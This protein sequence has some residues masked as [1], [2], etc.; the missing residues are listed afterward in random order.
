MTT[1]TLPQIGGL[2]LDPTGLLLDGRRRVGLVVDDGDGIA[3]WV[4]L[5][6][7]H[8]GVETPRYLGRSADLEAAVACVSAARPERNR[9]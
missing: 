2:D 5:F 3:A 4:Y 6:D 9:W 7:S 1:T 8:T